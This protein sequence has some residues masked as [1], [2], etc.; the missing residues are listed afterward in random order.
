MSWI[1]LHYDGCEIKFLSLS[2]SFACFVP[3]NDINTVSILEVQ[4]M[5][6]FKDEKSLSR[7]RPAILFCEPYE[8]KILKHVELENVVYT[9]TYDGLVIRVRRLN[10]CGAV[11]VQ[12]R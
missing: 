12:P 6:L 10:F 3:S 11:G 7:S 5:R 1:R 2:D 8:I 9:L 4:R